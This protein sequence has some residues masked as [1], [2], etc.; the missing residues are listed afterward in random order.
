MDEMV[1]RLTSLGVARITGNDAVGFMQAHFC[2]D[3]QLTVPGRVQLSGYCSPKGRLL[4]VFHLAHVAEQGEETFVLV[5][6][7]E[8]LKSML[9]RLSMFAKMARP[10][11]K[12]MFAQVTRT[13][14]N[15]RD[16]SDELVILGVAGT[17]GIEA[18]AASLVAE[19]RL[20]V[21]GEA[22][23]DADLSLLA[24]ANWHPDAELSNQTAHRI[25]CIGSEAR[26]A[27][28][29]SAIAQSA[30]TPAENT[31][32]ERWLQED[33]RAGVPVIY[34]ETQDQFVPQ[35]ANMHKLDGLSFTKGCYPGQE[36][37]ARMQYLGKLKRQTE[38]F[39]FKGEAIAS[40]TPVI[41]ASGAEAGIV[42]VSASSEGIGEALVVVR[43]ASSAE[44]LATQ[45][46]D[47]TKVELTAAPLPY[48]LDS[49]DGPSA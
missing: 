8:V 5:A 41:D 16:C 29:E 48:V 35:M 27:G 36:I 20:P 37:V 42:M 33:V 19:Q 23:G 17:S 4:A 11:G 10:A 6:P 46:E 1:V 49:A 21:V 7:R 3:V 13:D 12:Q 44:T 24:P 18:V 40:G 26:I 22:T 25:L 43:I 30:E 45:R 47:G 39:V 32:E 38:R 9:D 14:V 28:I 34:Q 2:N 31:S 15:L